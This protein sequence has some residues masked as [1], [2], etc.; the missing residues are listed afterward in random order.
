MGG[1]K[2]PTSPVRRGKKRRGRRLC[3][4]NEHGCGARRLVATPQPSSPTVCAAPPLLRPGS[5]VPS[6]PVRAPS[7]SPLPA[8]PA[9]RRPATAGCTPPAETST[10]CSRPT[11]TSAAPPSAAPARPHRAPAAASPA[12]APPPQAE[13]PPAPAEDSSHGPVSPR[14]AAASAPSPQQTRAA[15]GCRRRHHPSPLCSREGTSAEKTA[16]ATPYLQQHRAGTAPACRFCPWRDRRGSTTQGCVPTPPAPPVR[17]PR[18][19]R[20]TAPAPVQ[21]QAQ[22]PQPSLRL[23]GRGWGVCAGCGRQGPECCSRGEPLALLLLL[24]PPLP[25]SAL[26]PVP[27]RTRCRGGEA[28]AG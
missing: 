20:R 14:C 10:P 21:A 8:A 3:K 26:L 4:K 6:A 1:V 23:R 7:P 2:T 27:R 28:C 17:W 12:P 19:G 18:L 15:C 13:A 5:V 16:A 24:P 9:R 11:G 22:A 25:P